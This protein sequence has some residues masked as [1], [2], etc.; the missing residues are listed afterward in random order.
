MNCS[1]EE[2]R[3]YVGESYVKQNNGNTRVG[4][5]MSVVQQL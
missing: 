1:K 5:S 4:E 2:E 3:K